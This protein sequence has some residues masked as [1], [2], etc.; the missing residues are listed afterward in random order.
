MQVAAVAKRV[1]ELKAAGTEFHEVVVLC[2]TNEECLQ[3]ATEFRVR[4]I[5]AYVRSGE[6]ERTSTT[7]L[8]EE[9]A[10]WAT[11]GRELSGI[12][13]GDLMHRWRDLIGKRGTASASVEAV[14]A[15]LE[16][17]ESGIAPASQFM[18]DLL[19][20]DLVFILK[21]N[22]KADESAALALMNS[23]IKAKGPK[24]RVSDLAGRARGMSCVQIA[25][26]TSGKGLEF[27][28]VL[29]VG[30]DEGA[31]P[32]FSS[33]RPAALAEDRRKFYVCLTRARY[34]VDLYFSGFRVNQYGR[35][36][37]SGP[38]RYLKQIG[39]L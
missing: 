2:G 33:T 24:F 31:M 14:S 23:W 7:S 16:Y 11:A 29:V 10:A 3:V 20:D 39:V 35:R 4:G 25:T 15:L 1:G 18:S 12:R 6:Y 9:M 8:I 17:E 22:G 5:P 26:M 37:N 19:V 27:D 21:A 13:L 28:S 34:S 30:V 32:H 38:S 36:F